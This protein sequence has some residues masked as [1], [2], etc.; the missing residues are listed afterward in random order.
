VAL[1]T[2]IY[3]RGLRSRRSGANAP[4][5]PS[6]T[7]DKRHSV[8][9]RK[10]S[11][12]VLS[13]PA[14]LPHSLSAAVFIYAGRNRSAAAAYCQGAR[15]LGGL[16]RTPPPSCAP[17][18]RR[19]TPKESPQQQQPNQTTAQIATKPTHT[20]RLIESAHTTKCGAVGDKPSAPRFRFWQRLR[21]RQPRKPIHWTGSHAPIQKLSVRRATPANEGGYAAPPS[22]RLPTA[23]SFERGTTD[24]TADQTKKF[25]L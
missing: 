7:P 1:R 12:R 24:K 8:V 25:R 13:V 18:S 2:R 14:F 15:A 11:L 17:A 4:S 23:H 19:L 9:S 20:H 10:R 5:L 6:A 22:F 16:P 21:P 3:V